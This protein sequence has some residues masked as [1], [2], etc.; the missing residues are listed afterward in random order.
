MSGSFFGL[1][2]SEWEWLG[3]LRDHL[4]TPDILFPLSIGLGAVQV[5]FR[6][7]DQRLCHGPQPSACAMRW[8]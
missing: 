1:Q 6:H 5:L 3:S 4:L 7:D 2:L 8:D